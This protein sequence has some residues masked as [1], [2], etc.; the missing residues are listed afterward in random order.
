M[1]RRPPRSTLSSSSA[2]SDVYKRQVAGCILNEGD[3]VM[4]PQP[5]FAEY[6][7]QCRVAGAKIVYYP[8][9]SLLSISE[10]AL[11]SARIL[12]VCNPNNPTGYVNSREDVIRLVEALP[13]T[14]IAV[15]EAYAD[16]GD[17]SVVSEIENFSNLVVLRTMSK[18]FGLANLRVGCAVACEAMASDIWKVKVPYNL[19]GPS[20]LL[21]ELALENRDRIEPYIQQVLSLIHI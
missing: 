7:Q 5:T 15:D 20:Q 14:V 18:A 3:E 16:F 9:E 11:E 6:E 10:D 2:A 4:I 21:A 17:Q 19:N 1:I 8:V 13:D 12:F